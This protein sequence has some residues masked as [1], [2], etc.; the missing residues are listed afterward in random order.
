[1]LTQSKLI[2]RDLMISATVFSSEKRKSSRLLK[3]KTFQK[4][5]KLFLL[6]EENQSKIKPFVHPTILKRLKSFGEL[7][8]SE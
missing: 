2:T 7:P 8:V 1:M 6:C 4:Y 3:V 5:S